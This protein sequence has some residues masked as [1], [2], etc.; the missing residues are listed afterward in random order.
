MLQ[1]CPFCFHSSNLSSSMA[2]AC[3]NQL[4]SKA[5]HRLSFVGVIVFAIS[6]GIFL[7]AFTST[8]VLESRQFRCYTLQGKQIATDIQEQCY[9]KYN[10]QYNGDFPYFVL[11]LLNFL[12]V[13][14]ICLIY[15]QYVKPRVES[16]DNAVRV[17]HFSVCTLYAVH[18]LIRFLVVALFLVLQW[19]HF[20]PVKFP[21][22]N[23]CTAPVH[24]STTAANATMEHLMYYCKNRVAHTKSIFGFALF[25]VNLLFTVISLVEGMY[26]A[27]NFRKYCDDQKFCQDYLGSQQQGT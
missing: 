3:L 6:G 10:V 5:Y 23:A 26:L 14:L 25:A 12:L 19:G 9:Q 4:V 16:N 13:L 15:S 22:Q 8:E 17:H 18:L 2:D 20:Y 1:V 7:T 21:A 27:C 24:N 11:V